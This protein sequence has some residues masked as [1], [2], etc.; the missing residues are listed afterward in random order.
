[1]AQNKRNTYCTTNRGNKMASD[2]PYTTQTTRCNIET[3]IVPEPSGY[4]E[5]G[6]AK[7]NLEK[8]N[9]M[10]TA[11]GWAKLE[12]AKGLTWDRAPGSTYVPCRN[13]RREL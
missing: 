1:M 7:N 3:C 4:K 8:N 2:C 5:E 11:A 13:I 9:R 6:H 10:G 12:G